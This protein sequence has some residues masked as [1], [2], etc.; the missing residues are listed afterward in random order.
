MKFSVAF[1]NFLG[2][3]Q[4]ENGELVLNEEKAAIVRRIYGLFL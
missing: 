1:S 4:G 3:D 2:Y